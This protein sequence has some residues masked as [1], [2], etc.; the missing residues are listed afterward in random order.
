MKEGYIAFMPKY[1][2]TALHSLAAMYNH[3]NENHPHSALKY[4]LPRKYW[5]QRALLT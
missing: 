4:G 2:L 3:Y 5:R 1:V